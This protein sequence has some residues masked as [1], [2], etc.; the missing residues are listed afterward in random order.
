MTSC[1]SSIKR[2]TRCEPTKLDLEKNKDFIELF[3]LYPAPPVIY[4][5]RKNDL[6]EIL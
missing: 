2:S 5:E 1:P 6:M 3:K 4:E